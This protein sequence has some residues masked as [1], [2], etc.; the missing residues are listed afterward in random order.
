V[1]VET[2]KIIPAQ[3]ANIHRT[4]MNADLEKIAGRAASP[5]ALAESSAKQCD[6]AP[7]AQGWQCQERT[8]QWEKSPPEHGSR[9]GKGA[10]TSRAETTIRL[11]SVRAATA[12]QAPR[13]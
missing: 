12:H 7:D 13:S 2:G 9:A 3:M 5:P 1:V 4:Y 8:K 6:S 11:R 10:G